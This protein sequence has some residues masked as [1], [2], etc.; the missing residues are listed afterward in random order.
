MAEAGRRM[1]ADRLAA[2]VA[3][4]DVERAIDEHRK[5][6]PAPVRTT[7]RAMLLSLRSAYAPLPDQGGAS[8]ASDLG[9]IPSLFAKPRRYRRVPRPGDQLLRRQATA[10]GCDAERI[11]RAG[12]HAFGHC[13]C[14]Q[15]AATAGRASD[16]LARA[17]IV[18]VPEAHRR[19]RRPSGGRRLRWVECRL[20]GAGRARARAAVRLPSASGC[21]RS[22]RC[23]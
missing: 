9:A 13:G 22:L 17:A 14:G 15:A 7:M 6:K 1:P 21:S 10:A 16:D 19:G 8:M 20:P 23:S 12:P 18:A 2:I 4:G 3:I 5:A 11:R